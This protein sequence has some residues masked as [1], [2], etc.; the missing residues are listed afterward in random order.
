MDISKIIEINTKL[1]AKFA[2]LMASNP[3]GSQKLSDDEL[4]NLNNNFR[5]AI[6]LLSPYLDNSVKEVVFKSVSERDK[7]SDIVSSIMGDAYKADFNN[8]AINSVKSVDFNDYV[9][10]V[11]EIVGERYASRPNNYFKSKKRLVLI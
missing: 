1:G 7:L 9:N 4:I 8:A 6:G 10:D 2:E 3:D 5:N 11:I